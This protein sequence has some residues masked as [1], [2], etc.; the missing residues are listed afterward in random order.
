MRYRLIG[1]VRMENGCVLVA[2]EPRLYRDVIADW[3][4]TVRPD[5]DVIAVA[6]S[7]L[8]L[9]VR[10]LAPEVVFASQEVVVLQSSVMSWITVCDSDTGTV[11][12]RRRDGITTKGDLDLPEILSALPPIGQLRELSQE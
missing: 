5:L 6:T 1:W 10:R 11:V 8:E 4:R 2:N 3:L 12:I 9:L 7:D